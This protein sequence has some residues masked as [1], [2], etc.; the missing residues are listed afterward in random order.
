MKKFLKKIGMGILVFFAVV[1]VIA[2]ATSDEDRNE[3][4]DQP[5]MDTEHEWYEGGT[6]HEG[7]ITDWIE[8]T[9]D[10]KLATSGDFVTSLKDPLELDF[11]SMDELKELASELVIC[12]DTAIEDL[13][14]IETWKTSDVAIWCAM[15][16]WDFEE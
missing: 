1:I 14:N 5:D 16:T 7:D 15:L 3:T 4:D 11:S 6:L 13:E 10:D 9:M 8:A 2:I 12:I